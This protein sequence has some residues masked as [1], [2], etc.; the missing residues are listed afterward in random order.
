MPDGQVPNEAEVRI[1]D[2]GE[3]VEDESED[4]GQGAMGMADVIM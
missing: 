4:F 2:N 1:W 3:P